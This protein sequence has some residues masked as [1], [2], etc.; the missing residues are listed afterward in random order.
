MFSSREMEFCH[1]N[2]GLEGSTC[3]CQLQLKSDYD[4]QMLVGFVESYFEALIANLD[5]LLK[6]MTLRFFETNPSVNIKGLEYLTLLFTVLSECDDGY[7]L[8]EMEATSF[9]PYIITKIGNI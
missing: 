6:W 1:S 3:C 9:I 5:L 4:V 2:S 8:H 7:N